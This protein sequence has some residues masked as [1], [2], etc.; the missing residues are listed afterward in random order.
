M[1]SI[2]LQIN[3]SPERMAIFNLLL[4]DIE[5]IEAAIGSSLDWEELPEKQTSYISLRKPDS[6]P[7]NKSNWPEQQ[8]W[9]LEKLE[10]FRAT[11]GLRIKDMDVDEWHPEEDNTEA[12]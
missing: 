4:Q 11:F 5:E 1:I 8:A 3:K 2:R 9:M 7:A 10:L 6:D 12:E